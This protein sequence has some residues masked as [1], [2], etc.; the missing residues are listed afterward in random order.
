[1]GEAQWPKLLHTPV[2]LGYL[3]NIMARCSSLLVSG[4]LLK[5]DVNS[6][7]QVIVGDGSVQSLPFFS[8]ELSPEAQE[9][10]ALHWVC[11]LGCWECA[12]HCPATA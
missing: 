10:R 11:A 3:L 7:K 5:L 4:R 6:A 9:V 8:T 2:R 1:M 12:G